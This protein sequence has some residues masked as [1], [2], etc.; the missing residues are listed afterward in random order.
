M[1][2]D[3]DE[4]RDGGDAW[5]RYAGGGSELSCP[6]QMYRLPAPTHADRAR[7]SVSPVLWGFHGGFI[8]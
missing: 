3:A 6:F 7:S 2:R 4:C 5:G 8:T 1:L